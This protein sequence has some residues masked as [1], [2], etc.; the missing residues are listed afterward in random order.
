MPKIIVKIL[1]MKIL[2]KIEQKQSTILRLPHVHARAL[3]GRRPAALRPDDRHTTTHA[4]EEEALRPGRHHPRPGPA[5]PRPADP[6]C[7]RPREAAP[8]R[9]GALPCH[10]V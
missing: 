4:E 5:N 9:P 7:G 8:D 2:F 10:G 3:P 6:L 1:K